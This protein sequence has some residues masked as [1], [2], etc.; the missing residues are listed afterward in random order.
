MAGRRYFQEWPLGEEWVDRSGRLSKRAF[1]WVNNYVARWLGRYQLVDGPVDPGN[2]NSGG[3]ASYTATI[4]GARRGDFARAAFDQL[5]SGITLSADVTA[6]DTVTVWFY[7]LSGGA[8]DLPAGTLYV[9]VK[10]RQ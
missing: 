7:N 1:S 3:S 4:P 6:N 8:I 5:A 2:I 9:E 10:A